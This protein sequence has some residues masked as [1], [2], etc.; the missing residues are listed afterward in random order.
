MVGDTYDGRRGLDGPFLLRRRSRY[1]C[2]GDGHGLLFGRVGSDS[3]GG[4]VASEGD[5]EV[6]LR[7][8]RGTK[9]GITSQVRILYTAHVDHS[10]F[11]CRQNRN[12]YQRK[13]R[14]L[15]RRIRRISQLSASEFPYLP[16][17]HFCDKITKL[18]TSRESKGNVGKHVIPFIPFIP[19]ATGRRQLRHSSKDSA[20]MRKL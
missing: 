11:A 9:K 7:T 20:M 4:V 10:N 17:R 12:C 18:I 19:F 13:S 1:R 15:E 14:R 2:L 3:H 6:Y 16:I 5:V 8:T